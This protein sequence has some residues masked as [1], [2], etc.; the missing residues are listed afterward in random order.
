MMYQ[1]FHSG[2]ALSNKH[3]VNGSQLQYCVKACGTA[4]IPPFLTYNNGRFDPMVTVSAFKWSTDNKHLSTPDK[5][6]RQSDAVISWYLHNLLCW[7][8][9]CVTRRAGGA[10]Q[11]V[12]QGELLSEPSS[13]PTAGSGND[14]NIYADQFQW[15]HSG[16]NWEIRPREKP[17]ETVALLEQKCWVAFEHGMQSSNRPDSPGISQSA[18]HN[19]GWVDPIQVCQ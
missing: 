15:G 9:V 12:S 6:I 3:T 18:P 14:M 7:A 13:C 8:V 4:N 1:A 10:G 19:S 17:P 2:L 11:R 5:R 16:S